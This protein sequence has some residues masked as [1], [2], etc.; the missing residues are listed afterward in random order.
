MIRRVLAIVATLLTG[1]VGALIVGEYDFH[2]LTPYVSGVLFGLVVAE[3]DLAI[4][5]DT[6]VGS[7]AAVAVGAAGGL[8]WAAWISS[9]RGVA[10]VPAGAWLGVAIAG[11]VGFGWV[12]MS[13]RHTV[14]RRNPDNRTGPP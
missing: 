13:A 1:A 3:V 6:S 9:G 11:I 12:R 4:G 7:A 2:G 10:P 5:R 14:R 8:A